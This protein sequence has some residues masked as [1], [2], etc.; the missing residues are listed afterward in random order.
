VHELSIAVSLV[1]AVC[2]ELPRLGDRVSVRRV[3]VRIG[4]LSGVVPDALRFAF[5]VAVEGSPIAG[6][7]LDIEDVPGAA[8]ELSA[9]EIVDDAENR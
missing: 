5:D 1:D 7:Y 2:E 6:A 4:P 9:V 3:L 8:L